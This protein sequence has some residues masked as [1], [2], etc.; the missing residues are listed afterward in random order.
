MKARKNSPTATNTRPQGHPEQTIPRSPGHNQE[1]FD[2]MKDGTPAYSNFEIAGY[3]TEI[4]LLGCI[5]LR[6]GEGVKMEW[7]G[8]VLDPAF[9][10]VGPVVAGFELV[11]G[12]TEIAV[13]HAAVIDHAGHHLHARVFTGGQRE[14]TGQGSS[15]LRMSI[16]Q[17][18]S[19]P[20]RSK[21]PTRSSEKPLAGPGAMPSRLVRPSSL[22][23]SGLPDGLAG[24]AEFVRVVQHEQVEMVG[25]AAFEFLGRRPCGRTG[26]SIRAAQ[27]GIGEARIAAAALALAFVEIV[28]DHADQAVA[29]AV[30]ALERRPSSSSALPLP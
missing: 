11:A 10:P 30:D 6:V 7:D 16:A 15:G 28:A 13:E 19:S 3:L 17:S 22:A 25:A 23:P 14:P 18:M 8:P 9:G 20:K 12:Q 4:I 26:V 2:M 29:R 5:A 1:W 21:Q 24:V 27:F